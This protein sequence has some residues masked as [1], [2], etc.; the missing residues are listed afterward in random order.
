MADVA[1]LEL[2]NVARGERE[3][4]ELGHL[5]AAVPLLETPRQVWDSAKELA[6]ACRVA[7]LT[8]PPTDLLV[9]R[10]LPC[11]GPGGGG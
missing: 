7:G 4:R 2:W 10:E 5:E 3:R 6:I 1:L 8:V 9:V 11:D